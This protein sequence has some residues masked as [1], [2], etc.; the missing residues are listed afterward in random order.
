MSSGKQ[1]FKYFIISLLIF[2]IALVPAQ[3]A[4][5]KV[6]EINVL[7]PVGDTNL[8][9]DMPVMVGKDSPFFEAF[10]DTQRVN[11]LLLG[12]NTGLS[13]TIMLVSF[14]MEAKHV[15]VISVPRDTYFQRK[16]YNTDAERKI[17]AAYRKDPLNTAMAVSEVLMG[18]PIHYYA[19]V[20]YD[21]IR[22]IVDKIGG[23]PMDI[24]KPMKYKDPTDKP[25]LVIDIPSG[26]QVLDGDH[27]VQFLR[28]RSGYPE[29]DIGRVKAQQEF[30]K[31]A[32]RQ[33][34]K[35]GVVETAKTVKENVKSDINLGMVLQ[36]AEKAVGINP[37]DINT[38]VMP[39]TADPNPP[40]YVYPKAEEIGEILK[41]I[42]S[43]K[44]ETTTGGA[45]TG[46]AVE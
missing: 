40:Y 6:A 30:M 20:D 12:I 38:Y 44:P 42:Y 36:I 24:K 37:D 39:Y 35:Y 4:L 13:D 45:V 28:Y 41:E 19:V 18:M 1:F 31:S 26:Q 7:N 29:G 5:R 16:G 11:V 3:M 34:L 2:T 9:K 10:Q 14:D 21:G 27:A 33:A 8:M 17:N 46:G 15:D 22:N 25:P 32:F 23:V 43:I